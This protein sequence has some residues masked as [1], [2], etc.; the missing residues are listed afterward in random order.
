MPKSKRQPKRPYHQPP[1][2]PPPDQLG[3]ARAATFQ[4]PSKG[5]N[6]PLPR[7][8]WPVG[9]IH[10]NKDAALSRFLEKKR[11]RGESLTEQQLDII[12]KFHGQG[13]FASPSSSS[14][15]SSSSASNSEAGAAAFVHASK[16]ASTPASTAQ[17]APLTLA[18]RMTMPLDELAA[19]RRS[20]A[21]SAAASATAGANSPKIPP[22]TLAS[23]GQSAS[24]RQS[25]AS[26]RRRGRR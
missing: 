12:S 16:G 13:V 6:S 19:L 8:A 7:M 26:G 21:V 1:G 3:S 5:S 14:E 22:M 24:G 17:P 18:Q 10:S 20:P 2:L 23:G 9:K 11:D 4:P 15:P 25:K